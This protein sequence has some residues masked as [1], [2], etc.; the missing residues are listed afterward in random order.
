MRCC[1][2]NLHHLLSSSYRCFVRVHSPFLQH[3]FRWYRHSHCFRRVCLLSCCFEV[4][5]TNLFPPSV[6]PYTYSWVGYGANAQLLG[7]AQSYTLSIFYIKY[8]LLQYLMH[9]SIFTMVR[10]RGLLVVYIISYNIHP[11]SDMR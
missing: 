5:F 6:S 7:S 4:Q 11:S 2:G 8:T 9:L 3:L 10:Y 1:A